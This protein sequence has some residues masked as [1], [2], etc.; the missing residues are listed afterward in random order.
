MTQ[1][2]EAILAAIVIKG[3]M[4]IAEQAMPDSYFA[5]DRRVNRARKWLKEYEDA[6]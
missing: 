5:T 4:E 1:K 2:S 3:L 6:A